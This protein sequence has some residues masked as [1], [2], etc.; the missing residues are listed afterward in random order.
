MILLAYRLNMQPIELCAHYLDKAELNYY[1]Q[2]SDKRKAE[3]SNG[4][5][6]VKQMLQIKFGVNLAD[7][8]IGLP[9]H[10]APSLQVEQQ[11][12]CLSISHSKQ[13]VC[14]VVANYPVGL[15]MECLKERDYASF[16]QQF[17]ALQDCDSLLS[18]Y[19]RWTA[20]EAYSKCTGELL[21]TV[22]QRHLPTDIT[23]KYLPLAENLLC[24]CSKSSL[25]NLENLGELQ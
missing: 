12:L 13:A 18:F 19:R 14:A 6:L 25:N 21:W 7:I 10:Q 2:L 8:H 15:D 3:F 1:Q 24:L 4:R 23:L 5:A 16:C 17:I 9:T 20:C 11:R 22:L